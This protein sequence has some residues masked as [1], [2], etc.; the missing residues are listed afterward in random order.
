MFATGDSFSV[1]EETKETGAQTARRFAGNL[2][3]TFAVP[4]EL[5]RFPIWDAPL[6]VKTFVHLKGGGGN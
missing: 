2:G 4:R 3:K 6:Y 1:G 5:Y